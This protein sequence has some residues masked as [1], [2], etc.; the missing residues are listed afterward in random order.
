MTVHFFLMLSYLDKCARV[1]VVHLL[2][3]LEW[4][5][6]RDWKSW[7]NASV[8]AL[9]NNAKSGKHRN[10]TMLQFRRSVP[11]EGFVVLALGQLQ[12]VEES[13]LCRG[14]STAEVFNTHR[15]NGTKFSI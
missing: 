4:V 8:Q 1:V 9:D 5:G 15:Y 3:G 12:W 10:A 11:S 7:N 14:W 2:Q 6:L 13:P